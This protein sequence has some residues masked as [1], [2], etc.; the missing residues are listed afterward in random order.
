MGLREEM[1]GIPSKVFAALLGAIAG[2][3]TA[4][5]IID[6]GKGP[7]V[8][9]LFWSMWIAYALQVT[10]WLWH[11]FEVAGPLIYV[12]IWT[13]VAILVRNLVARVKR[14]EERPQQPFPG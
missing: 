9:V 7:I 11:V 6:Y 8:M 12:S 3:S 5:L 1:K 2:V 10:T 14:N 4:I 13:L